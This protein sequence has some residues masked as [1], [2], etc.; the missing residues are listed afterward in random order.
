MTEIRGTTADGFEEIQEIFENNFAEHGDVGAGFTLYVDGQEVVNLTGGVSDVNGT[1]YD[2]NTLQL[3]FSS[4][5]GA[6]AMCAHL[7]VERGDLDLDA[8]VSKYWPD[9]AAHGKDAVPVSWLLSHQSGVIDTTAKLSLEEALHWP[10]VT[11]ALADSIPHWEPGTQHGYHAITYGWLVGEVVRRVSGKSLGTFFADEFAE[12]LGLDFWIGLPDEHQARVAPVIPMGATIDGSGSGSDGDS[13]SNLGELLEAFLGPDNLAGKALTAPGGAFSDEQAWNDPRVRAAEIPGANAVTN[14]ASLARLYAASVS[15]VDGFRSLSPETVNRA[16]VPQVEGP[17][18]VLIF[19]IP[20]ALGFMTHSEMSPF[21]GG[22]SFGH[23]GAGGS[24]GFADPDRGIAGG[25]VMNQM[26]VAIA[27]DM[28]TANLL[29]AV[30]R[31][32]S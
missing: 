8:P 10:T 14:A 5:K 4:T 27:G 1:P 32:T 12:P 13:P 2:E 16:I 3:V 11:A 24:V 26:Q 6:T 22:R 28:R 20:F 31:L 19:P 30:D 7:L 23:Y 29:A 15:E 21:I 9:F 25:F 18:S 17:D